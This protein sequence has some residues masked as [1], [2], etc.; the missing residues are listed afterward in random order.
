[1]LQ[2]SFLKE[3]RL[4]VRLYAYNPVGRKYVEYKSYITAG[5]YTGRDVSRR[6]ARNFGINVSYR[7][8]SLNASVKKT[9]KSID[10]S[11]LIGR[12]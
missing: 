7:F 10:N 11:D 1:M 12:K 4:T 9:S 2:R 8:G 3:D 5:D 6:Y